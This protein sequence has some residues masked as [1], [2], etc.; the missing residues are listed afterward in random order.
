MLSWETGDRRVLAEQGLAEG[1]ALVAQHVVEERHHAVLD[2]LGGED[3]VALRCVVDAEARVRHAV[4]CLLVVF[5]LEAQ[6]AIDHDDDLAVEELS[7]LPE[8]RNV[9]FD[10]R[11]LLFRL[12]SSSVHVSK[13][14]TRQNKK[15]IALA[16]DLCSPS[17]CRCREPAHTSHSQRRAE[18]RWKHCTLID[19]A[20]LILEVGY[21]CADSGLFKKR[22][23]VCEVDGDDNFLNFVSVRTIKGRSSNCPAQR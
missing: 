3:A 21:F 12:C 23:V 16:R 20:D 1:D 14:H 11:K 22:V 9:S 2:L 6:V 13:K 10:Q 17:V 8:P 7:H 4:Q 18:Q 5:G 19:R 15:N